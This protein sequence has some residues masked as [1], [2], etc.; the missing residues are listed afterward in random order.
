MSEASRAVAFA[1]SLY[2]EK[3]AVAYAGHVRRHPLALLNLRQGR[4]DPYPVYERIRAVAARWCRPA[5][6]IG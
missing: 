3:A 6:A 5:R 4:A 1:V 2:R